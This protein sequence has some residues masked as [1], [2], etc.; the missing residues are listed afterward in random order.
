M[1]L[2]K[3]LP[4]IFKRLISRPLTKIKSQLQKTT[5][6]ILLLITGAASAAPS[7]IPEELL[8]QWEVREVH[9]D[10]SSGRTFHYGW[11]SPLLQWRII[12]FEKSHISN[13]TPE[14]SI[15]CNAPR[16]EVEFKNVSKMLN[17]LLGYGKHADQS[18]AEH[19]KLD[20]PK[21]LNAKFIKINCSDGAWNGAISAAKNTSERFSNGAWLFLLKEDEIALRWYD[22][23]ILILKKIHPNTKPTPSFPCE[24]ARLNA[25]IAICKSHELAGLDKSVAAAYNTLLNFMKNE[26]PNDV[27][28][29]RHEQN[30]WL[31]TRNSCGADTSCLSKSMEQRVNEMDMPLD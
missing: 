13:N 21:N 17:A 9:L 1:R 7:A 6:Y 5:L 22:Q 14:K 26:I 12:S 16:A 10:T 30:K 8:G 23:T 18:A 29:V 27:S 25:E 11:N 2:M 28:R 19:Y 31:K 4:T 20:I 24:K 3:N 15:P